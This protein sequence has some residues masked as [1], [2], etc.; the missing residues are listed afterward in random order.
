M[1][2]PTELMEIIGLWTGWV[3]MLTIYSYPLYK[4]NPVYRF[5]EH[6]FIAIFLAL[7]RVERVTAFQCLD[8]RRILTG[9]HVQRSVGQDDV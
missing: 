3:L 1:A 5:S 9:K 7:P 2:Y 6:L 4:E 8:R